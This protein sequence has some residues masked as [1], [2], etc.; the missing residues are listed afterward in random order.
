MLDSSR[1]VTADELERQPQDDYRYELVA[2]RVIR[3]SPVGGEH[4]ILVGQLIYLFK[5]HVEDRGLGGLVGPEIGFKLAANPDTVRA[6]DVAF[7]RED[8]LPSRRP[9]GFLKGPPDLAVEV[10]SPDDTPAEVRA[11]V[12]EYLDHGVPVVVVVDPDPQAVTIYRRLTP[13]LTLAGRDDV[14]DLG[15]VVAD[16]RCSLR[17]IFE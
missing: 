1:L 7:V 16:F 15:D 10:V 3:M 6:P 14:L 13:P 12:E 17:E 9:R 5:R 8:R 4:G 2:G 11:K